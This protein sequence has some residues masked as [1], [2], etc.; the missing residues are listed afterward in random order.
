M[1]GLPGENRKLDSFC[2]EDRFEPKLTYESNGTT[3]TLV[4]ATDEQGP[5]RGF[6][7]TVQGMNFR[8]TTRMAFILFIC[9]PIF[10][11]F[12]KK[13]YWK[14]KLY[15]EKKYSSGVIKQN[16]NPCLVF[17]SQLV[18]FEL[19]LKTLVLDVLGLWHVN[20]RQLQNVNDPVELSAC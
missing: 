2:D 17:I 13:L 11:L 8:H 4:L 9:L 12:Q 7:A 14:K 15:W 16:N 1:L 6:V 5:R 10:R 3:L 18:K 20:W 19:P